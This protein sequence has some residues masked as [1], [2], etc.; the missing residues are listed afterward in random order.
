MGAI[1]EAIVAY[2]KPLLE[3][4]DGSEEQMS[5]ALT[6]SQ[7]CWNL[8]LYAE[9]KRD[10]AINDIRPSIDMSDEEF[11]EFRCTLIDPMIRRHEEMFPQLH[12]P[13]PHFPSRRSGPWQASQSGGAPAEKYAGTDRYAPCP[14]N[15]G[16]KYKFCC[17][18]KSR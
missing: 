14:C 3:D 7:L 1:G 6:M 16:R 10:Q 2:A 8:A 5:W 17:G 4:S 12:R 18:A 13:G 11:D 15:S 9:D